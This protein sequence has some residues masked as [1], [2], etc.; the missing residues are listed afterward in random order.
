MTPPSTAPWTTTNRPANKRRIDQ[1]SRASAGPRREETRRRTT[2][3]ASA[4]SQIGTTGPCVRAAVTSSVT[5][6]IIVPGN[7]QST[8]FCRS[9]APQPPSGNSG[10]A[11]A[12]LRAYSAS[13]GGIDPPY[14]YRRYQPP[15]RR[16]SAVGRARYRT[17]VVTGEPIPL[18]TATRRFWGLPNGRS[19][20]PTVTENARTRRGGFGLVRNRAATAMRTGTPISTRA[21]FT[22]SAERRPIPQNRTNGRSRGLRA[23]PMTQRARCWMAPEAASASANR[24]SANRKTRVGA[25]E[26]SADSAAVRVSTPSATVARAPARKITQTQGPRPVTWRAMTAANTPPKVTA[27]STFV[28]PSS[29]AAGGIEPGYLGRLGPVPSNRTVLSRR[30]A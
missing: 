25:A 29:R 11:S 23:L 18:W 15:R 16:L 10:G 19:V 20:L 7:A 22:I 13:A 1:F 27:D 5:R 24:N 9:R 17:N 28:A 12:L 14:T 2:A 30:R 26:P 4:T 21:S 6:T 3:P 8:G